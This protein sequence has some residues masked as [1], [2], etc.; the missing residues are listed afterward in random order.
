MLTTEASLNPLMT[1]VSS[2]PGMN[3][4][5]VMKVEWDF[6]TRFTLCE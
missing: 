5:P 6:S 1:S 4:K 3:S 2:P